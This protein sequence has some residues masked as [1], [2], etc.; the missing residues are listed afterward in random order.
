MAKMIEG[1]TENILKCAKEEF[2]ANGY[3]NASLRNIAEKAGTT[4]SSLLYR[5]SDKEALY[6]SIVQ[7]VADGFCELLQKTLAGFE[8]LEPEEQKAQINSYSNGKFSKLMD[9]V[10]AHL[11]EFKIMLLSGE[12][13]CYQEFMHRV[14]AIDI[15]TTLQYIGKTGNDAI[16]SGRLTMELAHLLSSAFYTGLFETV[17][18]DMT[19]EDAKKHIQSMSWFFNA[20]WKTIFE[21][22]KVGDVMW[23]D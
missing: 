15:Q 4:K 10:F 9:F 5:Y 18:H 14:V 22:G 2:L 11:D 6:H 21:G 16:S 8:A 20:G 1:V 17:I 12:T 7:P 3:E 13:N 19:K 23:P